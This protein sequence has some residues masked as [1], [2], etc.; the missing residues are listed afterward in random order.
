ML[1]VFYVYIFEVFIMWNYIWVCRFP[2]GSIRL[3]NS[4]GLSPVNLQKG[5]QHYHHEHKHKNEKIHNKIN[6]M[7]H[8]IHVYDFKVF[9]MEN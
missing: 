4:W 1:H 6:I 9:E 8:D 5:R 7:L 3:I 2:R